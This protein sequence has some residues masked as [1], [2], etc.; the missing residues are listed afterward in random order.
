MGP[1]ER[2]ELFLG[3]STPDLEYILAQMMAYQRQSEL[4]ARLDAMTIYM[5]RAK[6]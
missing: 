6:T 1:E 5:L 2:Q 4:S 3:M